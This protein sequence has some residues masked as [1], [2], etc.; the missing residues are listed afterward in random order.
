MS[1]NGSDNI[2]SVRTPAGKGPESTFVVEEL[3]VRSGAWVNKGQTVMV[4]RP[5]EP[6]DVAKSAW[7]RLKSPVA[8]KVKTVAFKRKEVASGNVEVVTLSPEECLHPTVM[9][10]MCAD[11]GIDLQKDM[12]CMDMA[13]AKA[14]VRGG[15][16][17]PP[18]AAKGTKASISVLHSIPEL[19]V[20][21]DEALSLG[22]E[23]E[24]RLLADRRLVLL[25]DLDQTLIHTT[26]ED[27]PAK[28]RSSLHHFQLYGPQSPWYHTRI[29]PRTAQFLE[30]IAKYYELHICTFGARL[31]AHTIA[32]FLDK[33]SKYFSHRILSR[34]ECFDNRSKTANLSSLFPCGDHMVCIIDDREDVWNYAP[35]LVHVK[36]YIFFKNTGDINAPPTGRHSSSKTPKPTPA[37]QPAKST[38]SKTSTNQQTSTSKKVSPPDSLKPA[39][40]SAAAA[41]AS[42]ASQLPPPQQQHQQ[43]PP[44]ERRDSID[45]PSFD[46]LSGGGGGDSAA[47]D[48]QKKDDDASATAVSD[49]L[50]LSSEDSN[51]SSESS[52][53][54]SSNLGKKDRDDDQEEEEEE[55]DAKAIDAK[56]IDA[57]ATDAKATD[58]KATDAE[59]AVV[60]GSSEKDEAAAVSET[61]E[62]SKKQEGDKITSTKTEDETAAAVTEK[63]EVKDTSDSDC[64][65]KSGMDK[66]VKGGGGG[67]D[68]IGDNQKRANDVIEE[69]EAVEDDLVDEEDDG[70][71]TDDYLLYLE[72]TLKAIHANYYKVYDELKQQNS[73]RV[74]DLKQ[75]I[76][77]VK[78]K[79]LRGT[80]IVFSGVVPTHVKL[81]RSK[82]YLVAR[83]LGARVS[84]RVSK[85]TTH[86]VAAR[87]GTAKVNDAKKRASS[88]HL[89]TPDWLWNC[90]ERWERVD[91]RLYPLC[92]TGGVP[93]T[94]IPPA[95]CSSPEDNAADRFPADLDDDAILN[96]INEKPAVVG[97][98]G[99]PQRQISQESLP[100][101]LNPFY[102]FST[103]DLKG[104]DQEVEDILSNEDSSSSSSSDE[105]GQA[106]ANSGSDASDM[107]TEDIK[108]KNVDAAVAA[109]AGDAATAAAAAAMPQ[110]AAAA[111]LSESSSSSSDDSMTGEYPRGM[112]RRKYGGGGSGSGA[113]RGR[114]SS[115]AAA[116]AA[117]ATGGG[118]GVGDD[119][120]DEDPLERFKRGEHVDDS[121]GFDVA[122]ASDD[123]DD[124]EMAA[125]LEREFLGDS[126]SNF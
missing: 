90:A 73:S 6:P 110:Q 26:N 119:D 27:V 80:N 93:V 109:K 36:P 99:S 50:E 62:A 40:P 23:D 112:K 94:V 34:D 31:Y 101:T 72:D 53:S 75:V 14:S 104:M 56:A 123:E 35:N 15:G 84:E 82:P 87:T 49:D 21:S 78:R 121:L 51:Q 88:V 13:A 29:R 108:G 100:E 83:S 61:K 97:P 57:K 38:S 60:T 122:R 1:G 9:K 91:E 8:G 7:I 22:R 126:N 81:E 59:K 54:S 4:L 114:G 5:G 115:A 111:S 58:A 11:C 74:P 102:A 92:K 85:E 30:N 55:G 105:E 98:P 65:E 3:K 113:G 43:R 79:A 41:A 96:V 124:S 32:K 70:E 19:K 28:L 118:E 117:V 64:S 20:S 48:G 67:G 24:K 125:Q 10:N 63:A 68:V 45:M 16:G 12:S 46:E 76:P 37:A 44:T 71:D 89:V 66:G 18:P 107:D 77:N 17:M 33:D 42:V 95:H 2:V 69:V 86:C 103:D 25:V 106:A 39:Q 120:D 47:T 116:A 52:S